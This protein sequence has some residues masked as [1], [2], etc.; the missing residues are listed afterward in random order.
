MEM[1]SIAK[2]VRVGALLALV[3]ATPP[4]GR[5]D[6]ITQPVKVDSVMVNDKTFTHASITLEGRLVAVIKHDG[7]IARVKTVDLPEDVKT[8]LGL[9]VKMANVAGHE[10]ISMR[11][12]DQQDMKFL[13]ILNAFQ[14]AETTGWNTTTVKVI[15]S[16]DKGVLLATRHF[17]MTRQT[18][19]FARAAR[20]SQ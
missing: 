8:N 3:L 9:V 12:I 18:R 13:S 7:G 19:L 4:R 15:Q 6:T 16:V 1:F 20:G 17:P 5:A 10:D 14:K 2:A 11:G